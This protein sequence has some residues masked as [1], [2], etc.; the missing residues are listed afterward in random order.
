MNDIPFGSDS[1]SD[2]L[3]TDFVGFSK[4]KFVLDAIA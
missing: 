1:I 2:L 4:L 3:K